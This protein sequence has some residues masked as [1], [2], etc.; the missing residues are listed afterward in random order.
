MVACYND[1]EVAGD[2]Y[3]G[4]L[5]GGNQDR[6]VHCYSKGAVSGHTKV[7]GLVGYNAGGI[8]DCYSAGSVE[9][10]RNV[11]GLMGVKMS[12]GRPSM[13]RT[14]IDCFSDI[15][16]SGRRKSAGGTG[17]TTAEMQTATTFVEAGWDFV[18]ETTN[19][20]EDIWWILEGEDYPRLWWEVGASSPN[21]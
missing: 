4:G 12:T 13:G 1:S 9:G 16:T 17:K 8:R 6:I 7:G 10:D 14:E 18:G 19:G 20:T 5:V 2:S 21:P 3:V 11:G 15:E